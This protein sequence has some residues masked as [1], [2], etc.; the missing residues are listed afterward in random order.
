VLTAHSL[1]QNLLLKLAWLV[2][3]TLLT[4][5]LE[6]RLVWRGKF[7]LAAL[8]YFMARYSMLLLRLVIV[9]GF[10]NV[11][12]TFDKIDLTVEVC[13]LPLRAKAYP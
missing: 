6:I 2:Y 5:P 1:I 4:L 3:D 10:D 9:L 13:V 12:P 7:G 8:L 11:N